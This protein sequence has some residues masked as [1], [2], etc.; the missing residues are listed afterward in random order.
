MG[1]SSGL[2]GIGLAPPARRE[3]VDEQG[4]DRGHGDRMDA[5]GLQRPF[6]PGDD[7]VAGLQ[8]DHPQ[9]GQ[10]QD[11]GREHARA[12]T[13]EERRRRPRG[14]APIAQP[15][16]RKR[17]PIAAL[18]AASAARPE[19]SPVEP[20]ERGRLERGGAVGEGGRVEAGAGPA[21][22]RARRR[23]PT[24]PSA[25]S[26]RFWGS[27]RSSDRWGRVPGGSSHPLANPST[28]TGGAEVFAIGGG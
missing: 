20:S 8:G 2:L 1:W 24:A 27:K 18:A 17:R 4:D 3:D 23:R 5:S 21:P 28:S 10:G 19:R 26:T 25:A 11:G 15:T 14:R 9:P 16:G 7:G 12:E 13:R 6:V 22:R